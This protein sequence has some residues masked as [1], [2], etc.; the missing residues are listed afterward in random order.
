MASNVLGPIA[1]NLKQI[2][3]KRGVSLSALAEIAQLSKST[4]SE[5]ERGQGN[6]SLDTLWTLARALNVPL[7]ALFTEHPQHGVHLVRFNGAEVIADEGGLVTRHLLSLHNRGDVEVYVL[8]LEADGRRESEG[9]G[10]GQ[11]EHVIGISGRVEVGPNGRGVV[12]GRG[13]LVSYPCDVPHHYAPVG[14]PA[15]FLVIQDY[16]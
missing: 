13:D 2:R 7:H 5:L 4:L 11:V 12:A 3:T 16:P 14:G 1:L 9:H 8:T 10:P 15:R 6:P